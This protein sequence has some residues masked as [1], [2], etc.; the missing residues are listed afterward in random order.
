MQSIFSSYFIQIIGM[1]VGWSDKYFVSKIYQNCTRCSCFNLFCY[2]SYNPSVLV[3]AKIQTDKPPWGEIYQ[4]LHNV[5]TCTTVCK[6]SSPK[7]PAGSKAMRAKTQKERPKCEG[8]CPRDKQLKIFALCVNTFVCIYKTQHTDAR[9]KKRERE[10]R[11]LCS[12]L[13]Q[14]PD[15]ANSQNTLHP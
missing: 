11:A 12:L 8:G 13:L 9:L 3:H 6:W 15:A 14:Q 1:D 5:E 7:P 4:T 10:G 2:N